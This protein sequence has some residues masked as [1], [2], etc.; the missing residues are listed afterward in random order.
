MTGLKC[1]IVSKSLL[2]RSSDLPPEELKKF[3]PGLP[4]WCPGCITDGGMTETN[5]NCDDGTVSCGKS[6]T[7]KRNRTKN[8]IAVKKVKDTSE[9]FFSN[10]S[11][12]ELA[13]RNFESW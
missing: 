9:R 5:K 2:K 11:A 8:P 7:L 1:G 10:L 6:L 13:N 12:D 4:G 3:C